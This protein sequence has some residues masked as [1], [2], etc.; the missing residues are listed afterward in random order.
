S[1]PSKTIDDPDSTRPGGSIRRMIE[2]AVTDLPLPDSPTI[3]S[4]PAFGIEKSTPSTARITPPCVWKDVRRP[5]TDSSSP[6][7]ASIVATSAEA[8]ARPGEDMPSAGSLTAALQH[9]DALLT[10]LEWLTI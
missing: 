6:A 1:R 9:R 4:V 2:S 8:P 10:I 7:G 5:R 3:A